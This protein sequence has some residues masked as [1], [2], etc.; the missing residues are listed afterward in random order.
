MEA[1]RRGWDYNS[2]GRSCSY[3]S[4]R[5]VSARQGRRDPP[6]RIRPDHHLYRHEH[7][8]LGSCVDCLYPSLSHSQHLAGVAIPALLLYPTPRSRTMRLSRSPLSLHPPIP[9]PPAPSTRT[10]F[11]SYI[12]PAPTPCSPPDP[13]QHRRRPRAP[14]RLAPAPHFSLVP[15]IRRPARGR[16]S[17]NHPRHLGRLFREKARGARAR[18]GDCEKGDG[19]GE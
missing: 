7:G 10:L 16:K 3:G 15:R 9:F 8:K 6:R 5:P 14:H 1:G 19:S 18:A 17:A 4:L 2:V 12:T 11:P 13:P